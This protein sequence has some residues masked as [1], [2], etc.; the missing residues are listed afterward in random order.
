MARTK[1]ITVL[2]SAAV[3]P[4]AALAVAGCGSGNNNATGATAAPP[5]RANTS[6]PS[7]PSPAVVRVANNRA[8]GKILV[9]SKGRTLYLFTKDSGTKSACVGMCATA[10]PPLM[11]NGTPK[12]GSGAK[13]SLVGTAP[14]SGGT[15]QVTYKGHL[16]YTFIKDT[17]AGD[18]NGEGLS[19]FGGHWFA[20]SPS[21][22]RVSAGGSSAAPAKPKPRPAAPKAQ[23][24]A[25]KAQPA[26]PAAP[27]A[28]KP[29]PRPAAPPAAKPPKNSIPQNGGGDGDSDN[30]GGPSDG[31]GNV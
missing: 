16:L 15:S 1:P 28:P 29:Q 4:L 20:V 18:T 13:A 3:L 17:S 2:A 22:A 7:T 14:R 21:G 26:A 24:A 31:D 6:N 11:A 25:P 19:A 9:D 8:L 5:S 12:A 23:P 10:W 27:A 30:N